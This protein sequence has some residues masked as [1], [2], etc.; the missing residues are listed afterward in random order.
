MSQFSPL[1]YK[2]YLSNKKSSLDYGTQT[3][4]EDGGT[5]SI[6]WFKIL[7]ILLLLLIIYLLWR[8]V[9]SNTTLTKEVLY[10]SETMQQSSTY[11]NKADYDKAGKTKDLKNNQSLHNNNQNSTIP[12]LSSS[13]PELPLVNT[14]IGLNT[15]PLP[16]PNAIPK[17]PLQGDNNPKNRS[18]EKQEKQ[19]SSNNKHTPRTLEEKIPK[20]VLPQYGRLIPHG[21]VTL[22]KYMYF[23]NDTKGNYPSY[24]DKATNRFIKELRPSC[25]TLDCPVVGLSQKNKAA[26]RNWISTLSSK[27]YKVVDDGDNFELVTTKRK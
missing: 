6:P 17:P 25:K 13:I 9:E 15:P 20:R 24:V 1:I 26:Y 2:Y 5:S 4:I 18:Q 14:D 22:E 16:I 3:E 23:A 19:S 27:N 7:V 12:S 11:E 8:G 21:K 10:R